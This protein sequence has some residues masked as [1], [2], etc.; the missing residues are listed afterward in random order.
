[1]TAAASSF[2]PW[3]RIWSV[4]PANNRRAR[5]RFIEGVHQRRATKARCGA[6]QAPRG[7]EGMSERKRR[8]RLGR[9][10][11][12]RELNHSPWIAL[13]S[14]P[15]RMPGGAGR[16]LLDALG[17]LPQRERGGDWRATR[18]AAV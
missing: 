1:M 7:N 16:P 17:W 13:I 8:R 12:E 10:G 6:A 9:R 2:L 5:F 11:R 18:R 4:A 14:M 15:T 3:A